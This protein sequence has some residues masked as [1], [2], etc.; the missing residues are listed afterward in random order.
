MGANAF[1]LQKNTDVEI[2]TD[3]SGL[4]RLVKLVTGGLHSV[5]D[6][7]QLGPRVVSTMHA[8]L[9]IRGT[10]H[11][12]KGIPGE[13]ITFT[14]WCYGGV[15]VKAHGSDEVVEQRTTHHEAR[16]VT[17]KGSVDSAPYNVSLNHYDD[18][19]SHL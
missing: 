9:S 8:S 4:I 3:E 6:P 11:Y 2:N 17:A 1:L 14:W 18:T 10:S 7:A 5:F 15:V 12:C 13:D 16:V 19:L